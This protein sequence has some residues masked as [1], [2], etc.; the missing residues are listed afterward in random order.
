[1]PQRN[2]L[3]RNE[4]R[5]VQPTFFGLLN[6]V[7]KPF[8]LRK[9]SLTEKLKIKIRQNKESEKAIKEQIRINRVSMGSFELREYEADLGNVRKKIQTLEQRLKKVNN[10][11]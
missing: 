2:N 1:M 11:K 10:A 8:H 9:A 6:R 5:Y 4:K 3:L 7:K